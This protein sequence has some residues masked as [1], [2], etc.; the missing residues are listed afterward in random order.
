MRVGQSF[1]CTV[2]LFVVG[3]NTSP[4]SA[5]A[6]ETG[7]C[8][9][10]LVDRTFG[11]FRDHYAQPKGGILGS[12]PKGHR[13]SLNVDQGYAL[14]LGF[15]SGASIKVERT[16]VAGTSIADVTLALAHDLRSQGLEVVVVPEFGALRLAFMPGLC[17][18]SARATDG[19]TVHDYIGTRSDLMRNGVVLDGEVVAYR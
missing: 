1:L 9:A 3:C 15:L 19:F 14:E 17:S 13:P 4:P 5:P 10:V 16:F 18:V 11:T 8:V 7:G 6:E 2:L 12:P